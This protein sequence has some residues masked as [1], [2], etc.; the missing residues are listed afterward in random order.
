VSRVP[1]FPEDRREF[2]EQG[3]L[4]AQAIPPLLPGDAGNDDPTP[5]K[6]RQLPADALTIDAG[7]AG[8]EARMQRIVRVIEEDR[9]G[10]VKR[11][12]REQL[13]DHGVKFTANQG[14]AKGHRAGE[15]GG[16][17]Q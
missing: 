14:P 4:T 6:P 9:K 3:E 7:D 13:L 5:Y 17:L 10:R 1:C 11:F 8:D 16:Y 2:P 15:Q 12:R